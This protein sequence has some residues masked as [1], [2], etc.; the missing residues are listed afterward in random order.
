[1]QLHREW[2]FPKRRSF[3]SRPMVPMPHRG[4]LECLNLFA[5]WRIWKQL[6]SRATWFDSG[7]VVMIDVHVQS[8]LRSSS[9]WSDLFHVRSHVSAYPSAIMVEE[10]EPCHDTVLW[11]EAFNQLLSDVLN[12][13]N[14]CVLC[15]ILNF[16]R[17]N[18]PFKRIPI[19]AQCFVCFTMSTWR[20]S[21]GVMPGSSLTNTKLVRGISERFHSPPS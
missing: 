4:Q 13:P 18:G 10:I 20:C 6:A 14:Q 21:S 7:M 3:G 11:M 1:M 17:V 5:K 15:C 12:V 2:L 8:P 16:V 19:G 9:T